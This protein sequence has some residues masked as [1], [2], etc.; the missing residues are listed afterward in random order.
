ML[1]L[2]ICPSSDDL[3]VDPHLDVV[4]QARARLGTAVSYRGK[5]AR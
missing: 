4:D 2:T 5:M 1:Q 3:L